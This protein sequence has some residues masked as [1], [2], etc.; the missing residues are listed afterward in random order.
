M[1]FRSLQVFIYQAVSGYW[2]QNLEVVIQA[3]VSKQLSRLQSAAATRISCSQSLEASSYF[4]KLFQAASRI[5]KQQPERESVVTEIRQQKTK[6]KNMY[7]QNKSLNLLDILM[8][9]SAAFR[10]QA[11]ELES[12]A[13]QNQSQLVVSRRINWL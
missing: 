2:G 6:K 5:L 9:K 10:V 11:P 3:Q 12:D 1:A 7:L 4:L 13:E 8:Y